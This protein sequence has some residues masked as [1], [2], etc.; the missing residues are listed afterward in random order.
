M[1][2]VS[3]IKLCSTLTT[4]FLMTDVHSF[5]D[6]LIHSG[7]FYSSSSSLLRQSTGTVPESHAEAPQAIANERGAQD[8]YV[9]ARAEFELTTLRSKGLDSTNAPPRPTTLLHCSVCL[10]Q[11]SV[12]PEHGAAM[13]HH[14]ETDVF[15]RNA[16]Q[17]NRLKGR[18]K[19]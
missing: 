9:A 19:C 18:G 8:P 5:I 17:N 16:A 15:S 11:K 1:R 14:T 13:Q 6:S 12:L 2:V 3:E 4:C 10:S 7:H